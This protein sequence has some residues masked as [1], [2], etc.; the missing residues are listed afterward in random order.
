VW[1]DL[2]HSRKRIQDGN[3][4]IPETKYAWNGD[5]SL[6]YQVLGD[7]PVD[8]VLQL[9]FS[10][11]LDVNWSSPHLS[12]FLLGLGR[13]GRLIISDRRG[14]GLSERYAPADVPPLEVTADDLIAVMDDAGSQRAVIVAPS[15]AGFTGTYVA[16]A[17][18]DRVA[19]LVL[20]GFVGTFSA[21]ADVPWIWSVD[22]WEQAFEA[23]RDGWGRRG[24]LDFIGVGSMDERELDWFVRWCG[25]GSPPGAA[26]FEV[27][28][29]RT[30]DVRDILP[31]IQA[32]TLVVADSA[33]SD[34]TSPAAARYVASRIP[35]GD[36]S[37]IDAGDEFVWYRGSD[38]FVDAVG[39]F[40]ADISADAAMFERTLA[41]VLFT[42]I[43]NS[44]A[45]AVGRGDR[46]WRE[47]LERHH[48]LVRA[49]L[50]RFRGKEVDT[51][52]DG[53]FATFDG[54][55]RAVRCAQAIIKAVG[56]LEL[57]V[58]AGVHTGEIEMIDGKAGGIGVMIGARTGACAAASE[59]LATSTVK[60]LTAG[61][62]L[63]FADAGEHMLKGL[64]D[65][66][67]LYRVV[68]GREST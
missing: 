30:T 13:Y 12:R 45:T 3:V 51:A 62:G 34:E 35:G 56:P 54:P 38:G 2:R 31:S 28:H 49:L 57:E 24:F 21:T 52:G 15:W 19:G 63:T 6:A 29:W 65:V 40:V 46:E 11:H 18:P 17:H 68:D 50:S 43:V 23:A 58:R 61:S 27:R 14:F 48:A 10:S 39:R 5:A 32:P 8:L 4:D 26:S 16:A 1:R 66:W 47:V 59:V 36:V 41:T 20:Y 64:P 37:E 60:E 53:F 25:A 42:D 67:H 22:Q 55:A 7:G 9:G 33:A 44:T